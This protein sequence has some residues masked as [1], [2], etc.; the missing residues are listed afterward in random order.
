MILLFLFLDPNINAF[1]RPKCE[2]RQGVYR[3]PQVQLSECR[4]K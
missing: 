2:L 1:P 3:I 4:Q